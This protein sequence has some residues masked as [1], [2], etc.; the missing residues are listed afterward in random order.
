LIE[1]KLNTQFLRNA[2]IIYCL[3]M[4]KMLSYHRETALHGVLVLAESRRL[5]LGDDILRTL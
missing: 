1:L 5:E 3:E 4:Y 2:T